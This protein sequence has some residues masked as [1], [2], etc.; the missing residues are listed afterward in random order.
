MKAIALVTT[1]NQTSDLQ[2]IQTSSLLTPD[3][4]IYLQGFMATAYSSLIA[5][6][7]DTQKGKMQIKSYSEGNTY[8]G[9]I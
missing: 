6:M 8:V 4:P 9:Y 3:V 1:Q 7:T 2:L 5:H